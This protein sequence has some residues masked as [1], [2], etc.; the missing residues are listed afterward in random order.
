MASILSRTCE[1]TTF[2]HLDRS[3]GRGGG[4]VGRGGSLKHGRMTLP[5]KKYTQSPVELVGVKKKSA[6]LMVSSSLSSSYHST[7]DNSI[8]HNMTSGDGNEVTIS[9]GLK[10]RAFGYFHEIASPNITFEENRGV[11]LRK[12]PGGSN[13]FVFTQEPIS[14][15]EVFAVRLLELSGNYHV[16]LVSHEFRLS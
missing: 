12:K 13:G 11:A 6:T 14:L 1:F 10:N 15:D 16:S 3:G 2:L 9:S 5:P 8:S 7:S 4:Y